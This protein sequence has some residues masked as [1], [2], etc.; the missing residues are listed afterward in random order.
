[1]QSVGFLMTGS[2]VLFLSFI[3]TEPVFRVSDYIIHKP[4]FEITE[5]TSTLK[6]RIKKI[7]RLYFLGSERQRC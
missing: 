5:A 7:E 3:K 4:G 2:V 6:F 1:M